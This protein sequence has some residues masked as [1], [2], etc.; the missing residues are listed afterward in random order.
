MMSTLS[1]TPNAY[2]F[3]ATACPLLREGRQ[4]NDFVRSALYKHLGDGGRTAEI[5]INL[6]RRSLIEHVRQR[7]GRN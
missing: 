6:K 3:Q 7:H 1:A 4:N 2:S 5:T